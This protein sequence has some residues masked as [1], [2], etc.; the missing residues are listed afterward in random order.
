MTE[1][2]KKIVEILKEKPFDRQFSTITLHSLG[3]E[4]LVQLTND[5]IAQ[6]DSRHA[7]DIREEAPD[8][9]A[10]RFL[11]VLKNLK[12]SPPSDDVSSFRQAIVLGEKKVYYSIMY[13]LLTNFDSLKTRAYLARFLVKLQLPPEFVQDFGDIQMQETWQKYQ[14]LQERFTNCHREYVELKK[15]SH[16]TGEI[17]NDVSTMEEEKENLTKRVAR[18][19]SKV[20]S[21]PNKDE[22]LAIAQN[23]RKEKERSDDL[24]LRIQQQRRQMQLSEQRLQNAR[25]TLREV[26]QSGSNTGPESIISRME[27]D[28]RVNKY[29]LEEKLPKEIKSRQKI[30]QSL[31]QVAKNPAM[32]QNDLDHIDSEIQ[33]LNAQINE[34]V[35]QRMVQN[36]PTKDKLSLYR[37]QASILEHKKETMSETVQDKHEELKKMEEEVTAKRQQLTEMGGE[38]LRGDDFKKYVS[39][40]RTKSTHYKQS[41]AQLSE[42]KAEHGVLSRTEQLLK[43]KHEHLQKTL[44]TKELKSGVGGFRETQ[45]ELERVSSKKSASD[46]V[47]HKTLDD[48][49]DSVKRL[50]S[51]IHSKRQELAPQIRELRPLRQKNQELKQDWDDKKKTYD[52]ILAG[53]ESNRAQLEQTVAGLRE[54]CYQNESRYF[55]LKSMNKIIEVQL[56]RANKELRTYMAATGP[57]KQ[58]SYRDVYN[59]KIQEQENRAK[60]LR[61][62]QKQVRGHQEENQKQMEIWSDLDKLFQCKLTCLKNM[63]P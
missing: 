47:K 15:Q 33:Q 27:E 31:Q 11:Q 35:E 40:L 34:L 7:G 56:D 54:I 9:R 19:R 53:L 17:R 38:V 18:I 43:Q 10:T 48:M 32:T 4:Q 41:R 24:K 46:D 59:K 36:H 23:M 25:Q 60:A 57:E 5:I 12:Y 28:N 37:Q 42:L 21:I 45:E 29:L 3:P 52:G 49:S 20:E 55:Y 6:I 58:R 30:L 62:Q 63:T 8:A 39:K 50:N 13:Y 2:V 22:V 1:H 61:E 26:K 14:E 51:I 16:G 44:R